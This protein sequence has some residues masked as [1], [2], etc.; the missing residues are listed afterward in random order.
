[1]FVNNIKNF[2]V[3]ACFL[4]YV[5][6]FKMIIACSLIDLYFMFLPFKKFRRNS[7]RLKK[8]DILGFKS[9]ADKT[10]LPFHPGITAVVGPNGCGKSNIADAFRWVL[11][12]QS[13]KSMRGHKML[14][15]IFAGTSHRKPLNFAE[16]TITL[17]D[18]GGVLPIDY[19]EV[20][21]TR[22]LHRSGE[23]E[24]FINR[25]SVRLK[26]L[27][28]LFLD[29]G[30]GK[31]AYSIFEQGKIDQ[32]INLSPLERRYIFEEAAGILRFLHRK[33][34]ALR[35]LEQTDLNV[36]RVKDIHK[37]VEKQIIILE[38]QSEKARQYKENKN[39]LTKLEKCLIVFKWESLQAKLNEIKNKIANQDTHIQTANMQ[40][41]SFQAQLSEA[42]QVLADAEKQ[43]KARGEKVFDTKSHKELHTKEKQTNQ[44][45]LKELA[46]KEK[47]WQSELEILAQRGRQR[48]LERKQLT[49]ALSVAE[50]SF[51]D[52]DK[53]VREQREKVRVLEERLSKERELQQLKQKDLFKLM[54]AESQCE[55]EIRQTVVRLESAQERYKRIEERKGRLAE[56][57]ANLLQQTTQKQQQ[58]H[59]AISEI[60]KQKEVFTSMEEHLQ[61]IS[62]EMDNVQEQMEFVYAELTDFKARYKVLQNLKKEM[63]GFSTGSKQLLKE[64]TDPQSPLFSKLK[65]LYEYLLPEKGAEAPLAALMKPYAQ[66]LVVEGEADFHLVV[67]YIKKHAF[68]DVSLICIEALS[69]E[70]KERTIQS[71]EGLSPLS[72]SVIENILSRHFLQ[73]AYTTTKALSALEAMKANAGIEIWL[74]QGT[75]VDHR[76]VVY[77]ASQGENNVFL[78][79]AELKIL[80]K[81][82]LEM[83]SEK[84]RLENHFKSIQQKRIQI[85]NER[86][87][88]DKT[89]RRAEMKLVELNFSVQ[90]SSTDLEKMTAEDKMLDS[91]GQ[92]V[93]KNIEALNHNQE[94][95]EERHKNAKGLSANAQKDTEQ[96]T[97]LLNKLSE[98]LKIEAADLHGKSNALNKIVDEQRKQTHALHVLE[99]KDLESAEQAKR[100]E[101]EIEIGKELQGQ[102]E[103]K[104][105]ELEKIL[106]ETEHALVHAIEA[107]N[108]L[109]QQT[110]LRKNVLEHLEGKVNEKRV[111]LKK[112]E[113]DRNQLGIQSAQLETN[114]LSL[115]N[116]L[117]ER[118]SMAI[119]EAQKLKESLEG[120]VENIEKQMRHLRQQIENAG[121]I[122]MTS[123]EECEKHKTRYRFL[124]EQVDDMELS[125]GEL[126]AIIADLD[127][128]S[129]SIF[130]STFQ[131][132]RENFKK[133][134]EILFS[135]GEADLQF[136]ESADILEAGIEIIA[137]PPGKQMRS[138]NLLSGGEKCL[139]A[140][141]LLFAIFEVKPAPFCILDEID[142]P[143]DDT[144]VE[145]FVNIVKQF[146]HNCQFIIITHNKRTMA[147]ADIICGV[148]M[149][150][151]G[152]SK[153][154]SMDFSTSEVPIPA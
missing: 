59:E 16:V 106:N 75:Y 107:C 30:M 94:E 22:R 87:E 104:S 48:E 100:L 79:E 15:V 114:I 117:R 63:E 137:K 47:R 70:S 82:I 69:K 84:Q 12:E 68:Q 127:K 61:E 151:K 40:I 105:S 147:I 14:D 141:A 62:Q 148:S 78:R 64:A 136:T 134:F 112:H 4:L 43:L 138:I 123:I 81:K 93:K 7:V 102:I 129:R 72:L 142:A 145:R 113:T 154:L 89:I 32:I 139:T 1:M 125:R 46:T 98:E 6:L 10:S 95:L 83:E 146:V 97:A 150:E 38:E 122:N 53:V 109:E 153:L 92:A 133:N 58:L 144:N 65:G 128:E 2:K 116:E 19:D 90:K 60:E 27:H 57:K 29:S 23:S 39:A 34:E 9:F 67:D 91:D 56:D 42:K 13:A 45:R 76:S 55:S 80:D 124:N 25:Q 36:S 77:F 51:S 52:L 37:E 110:V 120:P 115:E 140:M 119:S 5:V 108:E 135:G 96:L 74:D 132:V 35:K 143:L 121:D 21:I 8:L 41:E 88:L 101:K 86:T 149:E 44:E 31:D 118:H 73:D 99:V 66:T 18:I 3:L 49:A 33:K 20:A 126:V 28:A 131:K 85:Q 24:Y 11:G 17:T 26:D 152:V 130:Q 111:L 103:L 50:S 54:Q 71:I